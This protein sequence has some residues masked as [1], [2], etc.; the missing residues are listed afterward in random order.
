MVVSSVMI[1]QGQGLALLAFALASSGALWSA[2]RPDNSN[3]VFSSAVVVLDKLCWL[4]IWEAGHDMASVWGTMTTCE[5]IE[6]LAALVF[7]VLGY[8]YLHSHRRHP[9]TRRRE[10]TL[11]VDHAAHATRNHTEEPADVPGD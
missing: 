1:A 11:M 5:V 2:V 4:G 9:R 10:H 7:H 6:H 8:S 3:V